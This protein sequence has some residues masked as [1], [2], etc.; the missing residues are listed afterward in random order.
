MMPDLTAEAPLMAWNQMG[1]CFGQRRSHGRPGKTYI[2]ED[3]EEGG[4]EAGGE[5]GGAPDAAL[6][7]DARR[8]RR[9]L[10]AEDLQR[11]K[12]AEQQARYNEQNNDARA[13]PR[14][15]AAAPLQGQQE[16]DD[17]REEH[18]GAGQVHGVDLVPEGQAG[19]L[20]A[21]RALEEEEEEQTP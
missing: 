21:V 3:D 5:E 6:L 13:V 16:G 2:E 20:L 18:G 19:P 8:H 12:G 15:L 7:E 1:S 4:A 14:V 11:N 17:A 9:L 10:A